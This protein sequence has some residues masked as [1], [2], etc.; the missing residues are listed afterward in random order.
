MNLQIEAG[1]P[2]STITTI[3]SAAANGMPVYITASLL[4]KIRPYLDALGIRYVKV[5]GPITAENYIFMKLAGVTVK[6]EVYEHGKPVKSFNI[7]MN[8][9]E[10]AL[11]EMTNKQEKGR[12]AEIYQLII[13]SD[14]FEE[15]AGVADGKPGKS[16]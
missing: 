6:I 8:T 15:I 9:L 3:L 12:G 4:N 7:H 10:K 13:D 5:N 16:L 14:I 1:D 2:V 11:R